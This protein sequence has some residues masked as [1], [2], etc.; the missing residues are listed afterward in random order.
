MERWLTAA[1]VACES[2]LT[3]RSDHGED[4]GQDQQPADNDP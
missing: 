2:G 1:D 4:D 3:R